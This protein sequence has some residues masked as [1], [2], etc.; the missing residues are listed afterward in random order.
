MAPRFRLPYEE[1]EQV[2]FVHRPNRFVVEARRSTGE[3]I[4]AFMPNPGRLWELL[5]PDALLWV[6]RQPEGDRKLQWLVLA[7]ER[8][9]QPVF[10]HTHVNNTVAHKLLEAGAVP[11]LEKARVVR[12]EVTVGRSRFDFLLEDASGPVYL[13]VK[14]CTLF[15]NGVAMFPD[16]VTDRGRR[17]LLELAA[18]H[19]AGHRTGVIFLVH[20]AKP[21]WFMPDYH[22]D[23]AFSATLLAVKDQV[24]IQALSLRWRKDL[25]LPLVARPLP[26]PYDHI[27]TEMA[28]R[29]TIVTI[30][31]V[32]EGF[33]A[34]G[35]AWPAGYYTYVE[36]CS[37]HLGDRAAC[38]KS[39]GRAAPETIRQLACKSKRVH[40][41]PIRTS[42][43]LKPGWAHSFRRLGM[44]PLKEVVG[45]FY[46]E[47]HPFYEKA[48]HRYLEK[49]RMRPPME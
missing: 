26:I 6:A 21:K 15:G 7:V 35:T 3:A 16:A 43:A 39:G 2:R 1:V 36:T 37:A 5:L 45:L 4:R 19:R 30:Y 17:H 33:Q 24:R 40:S 42:Q 25:S 11:G 18:M 49:W 14:S 38:L 9:G 32:A 41:L 13:E 12:A 29:G 23:P 47:K 44:S 10:L 48:F 20:S 31:E 27:Q 28:D 34:N 22:T 8:D 46:F